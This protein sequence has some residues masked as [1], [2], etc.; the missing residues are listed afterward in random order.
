MVSGSFW[1]YKKAKAHIMNL[2]KQYG[3]A[4]DRTKVAN[5]TVG[6]FGS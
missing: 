1:I 3:L 2:S 6:I 5:I 4:I